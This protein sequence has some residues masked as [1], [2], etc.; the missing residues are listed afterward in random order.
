MFTFIF[1]RSI[2]AYTSYTIP[3]VYG[4][5]MG[6]LAEINMVTLQ[7]S[8]NVIWLHET[9]DDG[10]IPRVHRAFLLNFSPVHRLISTLN[11]PYDHTQTSP[12]GA[13]WTVCPSYTRCSRMTRQWM[14]LHKLTVHMSPHTVPR[15]LNTRSTQNPPS[16]AAG[17]TLARWS[18]PANTKENRE[19]IKCIEY[20]K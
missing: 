12:L 5:N 15:Y 4:S 10:G 16:N 6:T 3:V 13:G 8:N 17:K 2:F 9:P 7:W 11:P 1:C 18:L 20:R 14:L 19:L